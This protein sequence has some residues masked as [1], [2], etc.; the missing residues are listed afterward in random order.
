MVFTVGAVIVIASV[1]GGLYFSMR[2]TT[3][4]VQEWSV[5]G[6]RFGVLIF[7]FLLVG[8]TFTTFALLGATQGVVTD[9]APGYYVLGTVAL[10][11]PVGYFIVPRIWKAGKKYN[12][13][14]MGDFFAARF[15]ARWF[16][17]VVTVFGIIAL[18]LYAR[19][20]LT[21]LALILE[22]LTGFQASST[23]YVS[24]AGLV[25]VA[26]VLVG[27]MRSSAFVGI[28]KDILLIVALLVM[29]VG[30]ASAAEAHSLTDIF[31][32]VKEQHPAAATLPGMNPGGGHNMWWW[33]SFL[34]LTPLGAFVLPHSFQ[35]SYTADGPTTVRK[36]Q[37]LQP[38]YSLFYVLIIIIA[39]AAL[40]ALP[41]MS[42]AE[43]NGSL[44][45]FAE[46]NYPAWAVA[47]LVAAGILTALVPTGVIIVVA[48]SMFGSNVLGYAAPGLGRSLRVNRLLVILFTGLAVLISAFQSDALLNI[49]TSVYSA[50]GQLAPALFFGFLW[51][52]AT[53]AGLTAG[54]VVGGL[55]VGIPEL[56]T[57]AL[58]IF[59]DG[60]V[61]GVPALILNTA[62][63]Y[64]VSL[65]TSKPSPGS[66]A[67]GLSL[68]E[69]AIYELADTPR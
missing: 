43:A 53:A 23:V 4:D 12:L 29:V 5:G 37:I 14:T 64:I 32:S 65:C 6:R 16:G 56:A 52:R 59:P 38:L 30:V 20:Q 31:E 34:L 62:I 50:V 36:N 45:Y 17:A 48:A 13:N 2:G 47:L 15:D 25:I 55:M 18:L 24:L 67:V 68:N 58:S 69:D 46:Q 35:V 57:L 1:I 60:T 3:V 41:E 44:L 40:V 54:L 39:L 28:I 8:E 19:V 63:A 66:V 26:F 10:V 11:A 7:W 61:A 9:G 33:M 22:A 49:M 21:G 27:G 42:A 51:R